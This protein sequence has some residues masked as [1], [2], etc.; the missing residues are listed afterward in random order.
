MTLTIKHQES[1]SRGELLLRTLFGWAYIVIPHTFLL[2]FISIGTS[3]LGFLAFWVILFTGEYPQS[4]F[5]FQVKAMN[6]SLR[7][8]ASVLNLVDGYPAFGLSGEHEGVKLEVPYPAGVTRGSLLVRTLFGAIYVGIPHMFL[9]SF[10]LFASSFLNLIAWW[11]V[12]FT[13]SYPESW[14]KFNVGTLRWGLRVS[15]YMNY[16]HKDYPQFSGQE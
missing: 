5:E 10:R 2:C 13:G 6:W 1:Y 4:W 14:H 9:L 8:S 15:L 3:F 7:Y 12:L 16:M 11:A